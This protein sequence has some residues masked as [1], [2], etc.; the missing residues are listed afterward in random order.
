[1]TVTATATGR[2]N[3]ARQ[4]TDA[5]TVA[6]PPPEDR[7][8]EAL[9][10][11]ARSIG[12]DPELAP[13]DDAELEA[14]IRTGASEIAAATARW[15][16][17]VAEFVVRGIWAQQGARQPAEWLSWAVGVAP[18]TARENVRVALALR[19][20]PDTRRRF[21]AGGLSYS[22]VRAITRTAHPELERVLLDLADAAPASHLD[23]IVAAF[24]QVDGDRIERPDARRSLTRRWCDD[25]D[26]ELKLRVPGEVGAWVER[27]V[28]RAMETLDLD[29]LPRDPDHDDLDAPVEAGV[30]VREPV[31]ARRADALVHLLEV[32]VANL[33]DTDT[34]GLDRTTLV[35]HVD[36][37]S[38]RAGDDGR[39]P[40]VVVPVADGG[41]RVAA[42]SVK[43]LRRMACDAGVVLVVQDGEGLPIDV[44]DRSRVLS[45][46]L[47]RALRKRDG[48]CR[49]PGCTA[50]R[51][52][53]AHH[54]RHWADGGP[55]DLDNLVLLCATHHRFVHDHGWSVRYDGRGRF[56]FAP[57]GREPL[58][59]TGRLAGAPAE[60]AAEHARR[61][62][63]VAGRRSLQPPHWY[64]ERLD[65]DAAITVLADA[66]DRLRPAATAVAA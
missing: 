61:I 50:E 37:A 57:P 47:R 19:S 18:S 63:V 22:K 46:A 52:L 7:G 48:T 64:G 30:G 29:G 32:A 10:E 14:S 13:V 34:S 39:D 4:A 9:V 12:R 42:M 44:G 21:L 58:A 31:A 33:E 20:F 8:W 53:H 51:H 24:R 16:V 60:A 38:L 62:G 40:D 3:G 41:G 65:L 26:V 17:L 27:M 35:V 54:V 5:A 28:D 11:H 49:F 2:T 25:G 36:G 45:V 55:T 15:L 6:P 59:P 23:R 66:V 56:A 1:M 43:V